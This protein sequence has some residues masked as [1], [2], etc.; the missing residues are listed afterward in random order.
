MNTLSLLL[1]VSDV[2]Y[3]F[4]G[5]AWTAL[6]LGWVAY[7]MY[8]LVR[9]LNASEIYSYES[10]ETRKA[11]MA[12]R[13]ESIFPKPVWFWLTGIVITLL[14]LIPSQ[15]TFYMIVASEAGETVAATPEAKEIMQDVREI[16]D[17]QLE[18]LKQ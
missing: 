13:R 3:K 12:V 6:F 10:E 4:A 11:K 8:T 17:V 18:K 1:Y 14:L 9:H 5:A 15:D 2:L 16:I 7:W